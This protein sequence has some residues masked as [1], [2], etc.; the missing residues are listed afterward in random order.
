MAMENSDSLAFFVSIATAGMLLLA[1]AIVFFVVF[2]QK[3]LLSQELDLQKIEAA[4]Q[5]RLLEASITS[6]ESERKRIAADLHDEVGALLSATKLNLSL[7]H[8]S[9]GHEGQTENIT[10]LDNAKT[11]IDEA[12]HS[13]RRISKDLLPST[14]AQ[15]GLSEA[16][17][18]LCTKLSSPGL[19]IEFSGAC[20][21]EEF[22]ESTLLALYRIAQ[23][24]LNNA[25]KHAE[26]HHIVV[27][28]KHSEHYCILIV[29]DNG[30]GFDYTMTR[31]AY[32][33]GKGMGLFNLESRTV[34]I[35]AKL[36][37]SSGSDGKGTIARVSL[38]ISA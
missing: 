19:S 35:G 32:K 4:Y 13:V 37:F 2:Y 5:K 25:I 30:K 21:I 26:A 3:K 36:D 23:E 10:S 9:L 38:A 20:S 29:E 12:I 8:R 31:S 11:T 27:T 16:I 34:L 28:L 15:Y 14:L 1:I 22:P 7:L 6:Q 24:L 18:D 33:A 17:K